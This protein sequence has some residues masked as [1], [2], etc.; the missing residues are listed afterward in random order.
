MHRYDSKQFI[1]YLRLRKRST[2]GRSIAPSGR[3]CWQY[4]HRNR[5]ETPLRVLEIGGG[6]GTMVERMAA[7]GAVTHAAYT[8]V[9]AEAANI[10][11]AHRRLA[12]FGRT[13]IALG[14]GN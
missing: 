14:I 1:R 10:A 2:T 6:I 5:P 3:R 7:W 9:D 4:Y 11:A 13:N 12:E 8:F